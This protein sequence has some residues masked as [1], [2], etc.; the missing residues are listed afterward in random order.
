M[1]SLDLLP[2]L[3][4][5]PGKILGTPEAMDA[6]TKSGL[7][8]PPGYMT[9]TRSSI[10]RV[11]HDST[12]RW[13]EGTRLLLANT[14]GRR[15]YVGYTSSEEVEIIQFTPSA[16]LLV[17]DEETGK[18]LGIDHTSIEMNMDGVKAG[19]GV[20]ASTEKL[21]YRELQARRE[22]IQKR[23]RDHAKPSMLGR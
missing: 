18:E 10:V 11:R 22:L 19:F 12:G 8:L 14:A 7:V 17:L 6:V 5:P 23:M 1:L 15:F 20:D 13:G 4:A 21:T 16:V 2:H 3:Q 9:H